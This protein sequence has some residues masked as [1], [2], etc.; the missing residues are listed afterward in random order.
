MH[1][2]G[3]FDDVANDISRRDQADVSAKLVTLRPNQ[4]WQRCLIRGNITFVLLSRFTEVGDPRGVRRMKS[5]YNFRSPTV[6]QVREGPAITRGHD[7]RHVGELGR[8]ADLTAELLPSF[9]S[10]DTAGTS[11]SMWRGKGGMNY[12]EARASG[13]LFERDRG[14]CEIA[15]AQARVV[16]PAHCGRYEYLHSETVCGNLVEGGMVVLGR[17]QRPCI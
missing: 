16:L 6:D 2:S 10:F 5:T 12:V 9:L 14:E 11:R 1:L 8:P 15:S 7:P 4:P 3:V 13:R 17:S